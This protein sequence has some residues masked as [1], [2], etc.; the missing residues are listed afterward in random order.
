MGCTIRIYTIDDASLR[1]YTRHIDRRTDPSLPPED[2]THTRPSGVRRGPP[3]G[4]APL[5]WRGQNLP[6]P[7]HLE[8]GIGLSGGNVLLLRAAAQKP[9]YALMGHRG[10][11]ARLGWAFRRLKKRSEWGP[12]LRV[13]YLD[14]CN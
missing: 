13:P 8:L 12:V 4:Q 5:H 10:R 7:S 14:F 3:R 11:V 2:Q 1:P 6:G 9:G